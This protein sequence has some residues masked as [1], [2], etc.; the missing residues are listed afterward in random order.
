MALT[1]AQMLWLDT[2][3]N[4]LGMPT[5]TKEGTANG[6]KYSVRLN[7]QWGDLDLILE[8]ILTGVS[9]QGVLL[10]DVIAGIPAFSNELKSILL[11]PGMKAY[12]RTPRLDTLGEGDK[13]ILTIPF[14]E[15]LIE[16][17]GVFSVPTGR[18]LTDIE[19]FDATNASNTAVPADTSY[20]IVFEPD[21]V[22][23]GYGLPF[24]PGYKWDLTEL[25]TPADLDYDFSTDAL[26]DYD[27]AGS[28]HIATT[29]GDLLKGLG[30][31]TSNISRL[32]LCNIWAEGAITEQQRLAIF[33]F[34]NDPDE[35]SNGEQAYVIRWL[36]GQRSYRYFIPHISVTRRYRSSPV[37][38]GSAF[39]SPGQISAANTAGAPPPWTN[40]PS[41]MY[42]GDPVNLVGIPYVY[43]STG[44]QVEFV[45]DQWQ[46]EVQWSGF[47]DI[48]K[49]MY[50][51]PLDPDTDVD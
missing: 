3:P 30:A 18:T 37:L 17:T 32:A 25:L 41:A 15:G 33:S 43:W 19:A 6:R 35:A 31:D 5:V 45:G 8:R 11:P 34:L 48:D 4:R 51:N 29:L 13:A 50:Q 47:A 27:Q 9:G 12:A 2:N 42:V 1:T 46:V 14:D 36:R 22:E 20:R 28:T 44:P 16:G 10:D 40:A 21:D 23:L 49:N 26:P 24:R 38:L 39:P 7:G